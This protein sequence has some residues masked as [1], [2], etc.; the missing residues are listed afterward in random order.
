MAT[1]AEVPTTQEDESYLVQ[2]G[3]RVRAIEGRLER[4]LTSG[5]RN[6]AGEADALRAEADALAEI[7]VQNV[8]DR[9]RA[10]AA[11]ATAGEALG[12]VSLALSACRLVRARLAGEAQLRD[13]GA[14]QAVGSGM[15][16]NRSAAGA[17][18]HLLPVAR[19]AIGNAEAWLCLRLRGNFVERRVLVD[20]TPLSVGDHPET[21]PPGAGALPR[22][23]GSAIRGRLR[24]SARH[25]LGASG[26][27]ERC[28]LLDASLLTEAEQ[29]AQLL[30]HARQALTSEWKDGV[31]IDA[32][33]H[34]CI[35]RLRVSEAE[36]YVWPDRATV[37]AFRT[38][39]PV[40]KSDEPWA[41]VWRDDATVQPLALLAPGGL[42][43]KP[44][45]LHLVPG[46]PRTRLA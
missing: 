30:Q 40:L 33:H 37:A 28:T 10:V 2:F 41:V 12:A 18:D 15:R 22:W 1:N 43:K 27:I 35:S 38:A 24:W 29:P 42:F 36:T 25:A 39:P 5:W 14:W 32:Y 19:T 11:A 21:V 23:M 31:V 16:R 44:E 20:P 17:T 13:P 46:L 45:L 26:T 8:S 3:E 7:G 34:L 6:A 4:L 9:L